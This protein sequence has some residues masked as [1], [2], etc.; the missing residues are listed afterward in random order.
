MTQRSRATVLDVL[1]RADRIIDAF[2][3]RPAVVRATRSWPR[4]W[5]C[6]LALWSQRLDRKWRTGYWKDQPVTPEGLCA[7]CHR[8]AAWLEYDF[9]LDDS[10]VVIAL[11]GWCKINDPVRSEADLAAAL[12]GAASR[13]VRWSWK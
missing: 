1:N 8:R 3:Y 2:A 4:F 5:H 13:S 12:S 9:D 11:C 6:Q 10:T 7:A